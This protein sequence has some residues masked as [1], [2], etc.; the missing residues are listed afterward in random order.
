MKLSFKNVTI[1]NFG[2]IKDFSADLFNK[3]SIE[4]ANEVGKSTI[5]NALFWLLTNKMSDGSAPDGI[6]PHDKDGKD[7][8]FIDIIAQATIDVDGVEYVIKKTQ[9]QKWTKSYGETEK[10]FGGNLNAYE[11]NGIPKKEKDFNAFIESLVSPEALLFGMNAMSL[12]SLPTKKMRDK[13]FSLDGKYTDDEVISKNPEYEKIPLSDGTPDD[14]IARSKR[15]IKSLNAE[16]SEIPARIDELNRTVNVI[17]TDTL[18][19]KLNEINQRKATQTAAVAELT[20]KMEEL[21]KKSDGILELQFQKN[22]LSRLANESNSNKRN[23]IKADIARFEAE[24]AGE[25]YKKSNAENL[26]K[27]YTAEFES[28]KT[29]YAE[30]KAERFNSRKLICPTCERPFE[31]EKKAAIKTAWD[32]KKAEALKAINVKGKQAKQLIKESEKTISNV[33]GIIK[34]F[35][36]KISGL[37]DELKDLPETIDISNTESIKLIDKQIAEKEKFLNELNGLKERNREETLKLYDVST[38]EKVLKSQIESARAT[39]SV[40]SR[41]EELRTRQKELAQ[42]IAKEEQMLDLIEQFNMDKINTLTDRVNSHFRLIKWKMFKQQINGAFIPC[43]EL[44]VNGSEYFSTLNHGNKLLAEIDICQAF[45]KA[46]NVMLPIMVDDMESVDE[47][48]IPSI[49]TQLICIRRTDDKKL[50]V[51]EVTNE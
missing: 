25:N 6:R 47:W 3:T 1:Q 31:E 23:Q 29:E 30:K 12:L 42:M 45:Q 20:K 19:E 44:M 11:V 46:N 22:D 14:L 38:E 17:D 26:I 2:N 21:E 51:K 43:C 48:R 36:S 49:D 33:D 50:A 32:T 27:R 9:S 41:I 13:V 24:I 5:R 10:K 7:I 18:A 8:D 37:N 34:N 28:L 40:D 15:T 35:A 39:K 16:L 4:G